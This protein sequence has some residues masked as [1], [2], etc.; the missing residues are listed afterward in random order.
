M[1][2]PLAVLLTLGMVGCNSQTGTPNP[3]VPSLIAVSSTPVPQMSYPPDAPE[4]A[5]YVAPSFPSQLPEHLTG[6]WEPFR[7]AVETIPASPTPEP[8][9]LPKVSYIENLEFDRSNPVVGDVGATLHLKAHVGLWPFMT[10]GVLDE[11]RARIDAFGALTLLAPGPVRVFIERGGVRRYMLVASRAVPAPA[12]VLPIETYLSSNRR[13]PS[14][15]Q[16]E[17]DWTAF[18][19]RRLA[20]DH[21]NA[22]V[23]PIPPVPAGVDFARHGLLAV[24]WSHHPGQETPVLTHVTDA[25]VPTIHLSIPDRAPSIS[26]AIVVDSFGLY[27][28][29][30]LATTPQVTI[31]GVDT[32]IGPYLE[33][34]PP[35]GP[36]T[37]APSPTPDPRNSTPPRSNPRVPPFPPP[38]FPTGTEP[39][40][41][42]R[43]AWSPGSLDIEMY[44][45][46][47]RRPRTGTEPEFVPVLPVGGSLSL[48]ATS[49][50]GP[51]RW[52][53]ADPARAS[54]DGDGKLTA[55]RPGAIEVFA[56]AGG[57]R[58][59]AIVPVVAAQ[60]PA[61][62]YRYFADWM[63]ASDTAPRQ[64]GIVR[65]DA[66]WKAFWR[67]SFRYPSPDGPPSVDFS[68][69][70]V[71]TLVHDRPAWNEG[72]PVLTH[73]SD[74]GTVVHL[75][76]P[77]IESA[78]GI[79]YNRA[80]YMYLTGKLKPDAR[81][82]IHSLCD[83]M[84]GTPATATP[85][86]P[87]SA[88]MGL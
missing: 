35:E 75:A 10:W 43:A 52:R 29:P 19:Q 47:L 31:T 83:P 12:E 86:Q 72:E 78:A 16:S 73:V 58:A 74:N 57:A 69:F 55:H 36:P 27:R 15:I 65:D 59:R 14:W 71:V 46:E 56:E 32:R 3:G 24:P 21:P 82:A 40:C 63:V 8:S 37:P 68:R 7:Y 84:G 4:S 26:P 17:A 18:W 42:P 28:L 60:A 51:V 80:V 48:T 70:D 23:R 66:S 81:V 9:Q 41:P 88:K 5:P 13:W 49:R 54:I 85:S 6:R 61:M 44:Y 25:P 33:L 22:P 77:G 53:V 34:F 38:S 76:Y 20:D 45:A 79:S 50:V 62:R 2:R 67:D 87:S 64:A 30:K 39:T 1:K 11:S